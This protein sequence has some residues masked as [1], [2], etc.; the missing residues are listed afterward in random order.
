ME[1][2]YFDPT[3]EAVKLVRSSQLV[4]IFAL[5]HQ[6]EKGNRKREA[7]PL[8]GARDGMH[9]CSNMYTS[10]SELLE[11]VASLNHKDELV[12]ADMPRYEEL[13]VNVLTDTIVVIRSKS[14]NSDIITPKE[15]PED[16]TPR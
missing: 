12:D 10:V 11:G 8:S 5:I 9:F 15:F 6:C 3:E 7:V 2:E 1:R 13:E 16:I 14:V 4:Q